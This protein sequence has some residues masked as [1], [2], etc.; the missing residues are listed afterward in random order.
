MQATDRYRS[1]LSAGLARLELPIREAQLEK[2]LAFRDLLEKWNRAYNL[3]SVRDP[4]A[5]IGR[6]LLDSLTI[7]PWIRA[8]RL[9]DVG[10]GGGLPVIPLA[11]LF[12]ARQ[13]FALDSNAK[14]TRFLTQC[15]LELDL[16]N[17]EVVTA[18]AENFHPSAAFEQISARAFSAVAA[19]IQW[20]GPLLAETGE[21]LA[22][23][24]PDW[25]AELSDMPAGWE[26]AADHLLQVPGFDHERHL[27]IIRRTGAD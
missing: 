24:G 9:L 26:L 22:M 13:F 21:F 5:M 27:L 25:R 1:Q 19:M 16:P 17:L 11:I 12:P 14:K 3:T 18:R 15:K 6:H 7:A 2:L 10:S 23:K 4:A 20:C 8:E